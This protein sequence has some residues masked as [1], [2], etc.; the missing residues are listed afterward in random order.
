MTDFGLTMQQ[1]TIL[2]TLLAE[3]LPKGKVFV[4]GSSTLSALIR[5]VFLTENKYK[6]SIYTR[7]YS[8]IYP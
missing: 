3:H 2:T 8:P 7:F 1:F 6:V 5:R 4:Y